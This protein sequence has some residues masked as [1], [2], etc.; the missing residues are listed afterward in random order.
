M[1][2]LVFHYVGKNVT[3]GIVLPQMFASAKVDLVGRI[4]PNLVRQVDGAPRVPI[5][6]HA[7]MVLPVIQSL[8]SVR[9][10]QDGRESDATNSVLTSGMVRLVE[11]YASVKMEG[12]VTINQELV[13]VLLVGGELCVTILVRPGRMEPI[14]P[15]LVCAKTRVTA[16]Q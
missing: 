3:M 16:T 5:D 10:H 9:A 1:E 8:V 4:A 15:V 6:A 7:T 14:V 11:R 2:P 12:C 13:A